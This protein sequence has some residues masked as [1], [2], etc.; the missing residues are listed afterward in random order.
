M[1]A[2]LQQSLDDIF[3]A[4]TWSTAVM[5][6]AGTCR[7][8]TWTIF[9]RVVDHLSSVWSLITALHSTLLFFSS[10]PLKRRRVRSAS[11]SDVSRKALMS[12]VPCDLV[13]RDR[14]RRPG[15]PTHPCLN[16]CSLDD[17][18]GRSCPLV[19]KWICRH[20]VRSSVMNNYFAVL[21]GV[22]ALH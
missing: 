11:S 3:I 21:F 8:L 16:R 12:L 10:T 13:F 5:H 2:R 22:D 19:A 6:V 4:R 1:T 15:L 17:Q 18:A 9:V 14:R 20:S 7:D